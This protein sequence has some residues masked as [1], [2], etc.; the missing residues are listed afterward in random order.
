MCFIINVTTNTHTCVSVCVM[1]CRVVYI[2]SISFY[3]LPVYLY[4]FVWLFADT[5]C[6]KAFEGILFSL[7]F[8]H[9]CVVPVVVGVAVS[10]TC[11]YI[12]SLG[13]LLR[14]LL[15]NFNAEKR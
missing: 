15:C 1:V 3:I 5:K 10:H 11:V 8:I 12:H 6:L 9:M 7:S 13:T 4:P 14:L 2:T